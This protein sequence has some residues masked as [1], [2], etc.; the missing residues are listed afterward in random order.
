MTTLASPPAV[1][2]LPD[3]H[4]AHP[5]KKQSIKR[6]AGASLAGTTLEYYDHFV[7]G[8]AAALVFP[9]VFFSGADPVVAMLLSLASY[10]VAYQLCVMGAGDFAEAKRRGLVSPS[11]T[12]AAII[13]FRRERQRAAE[14]STRVDEAGLRAE[15]QRLGNRIAQLQAEIRTLER[16]RVEIARLLTSEPEEGGKA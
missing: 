6:V 9:H 15:A 7:Y 12:R 16:R 10:S 5:P 8:S 14:T 4:A 1:A 11:V 3:V 13:A 2:H